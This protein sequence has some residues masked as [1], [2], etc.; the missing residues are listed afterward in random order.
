MTTIPNSI[1]KAPSLLAILFFVFTTC[2]VVQ[3]IK[4]IFN[5][6]DLNGWTVVINGAPVNSDP[7]N[8][9]TVHD[10]VIHMY[11]NTPDSKAVKFGYLRTYDS[12]YSNYCLTLEYRWLS[13]KFAPRKQQPKDAGV[14]YHV[15]GK[16][17]VWPASIEYQIQE[18]DTGDLIFLQSGGLTYRPP[19]GYESPGG[20]GAPYLLPEFGGRLLRTKRG[21]NGRLPQY[22]S[23]ASWN[24][25]E[26][27]VHNKNYSEH[28]VNGKTIVRTG[29]FVHM[30]DSVLEKGAIALQLEGA[31]IQY[32][33]IIVELLD[34]PLEASQNIME[35]NSA[36]H[37]RTITI[38]NPGHETKLLTVEKYGLDANDFS[39]KTKL[40]EQLK[41]KESIEIEILCEPGLPD[42]RR[43]AGIRFGSKKDGVFITL[44]QNI[45]E[46]NIN[47]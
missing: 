39:V 37:R 14:L 44:H 26:I 43:S 29:Q 1:T 38:K 2:C 18:G 33:N 27:I 35:F 42:K 9:V 28:I 36:I 19:A 30:N 20:Q 31:E 45:Q 25:V 17:S 24:K 16:D 41:P 7:E 8:Y 22:D 15:N 12:S 11:E 32:R 34:E 21:Y 23:I 10:G 4:T 5:G 40:P 46:L 13:K 3:N 6:K 47:K